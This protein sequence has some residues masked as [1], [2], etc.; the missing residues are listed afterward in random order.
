MR[1]AFFVLRNSSLTQDQEDLHTHDLM[2]FFLAKVL[3]RFQTS[4]ERCSASVLHTALH[5][6]VSVAARLPPAEREQ[7]SV[8]STRG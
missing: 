8:L 5:L 7:G 2:S 1:Y 4:P 6:R 3:K